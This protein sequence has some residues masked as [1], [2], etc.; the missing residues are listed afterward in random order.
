M[1]LLKYSLALM[2]MFATG[3]KLSDKIKN[4]DKIIDKIV[5]KITNNK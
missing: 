2:L 4:N 1:Y 5:N 3:Q